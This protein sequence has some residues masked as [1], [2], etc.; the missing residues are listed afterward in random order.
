MSTI[1]KVRSSRGKKVA[2]TDCLKEID[3]ETASTK[4][5]VV[6]GNS[7]EKQWQRLKE[8][9]GTVG[10]RNGPYYSNSECSY[11]V[12]LATVLQLVRVYCTLSSSFS[13]KVLR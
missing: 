11:T 8:L 13:P 6:G 1:L 10:E 12:L 2:A 3:K 5:N 9:E 4:E 7:R